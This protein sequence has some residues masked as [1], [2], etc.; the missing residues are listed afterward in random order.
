MTIVLDHADDVSVFS[1]LL[2]ARC[3]QLAA[4]HYYWFVECV[5]PAEDPLAS[6][7][8]QDRSDLPTWHPV[9]QNE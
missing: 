8:P 9:S 3:T 5:A 6:L 7:S 4:F 1:R 2:R